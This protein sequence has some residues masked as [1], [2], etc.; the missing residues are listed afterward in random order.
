MAL[1]PQA[2]IKGIVSRALPSLNPDG[3]N[4]DVAVR[5][6]SYGEVFTMPAIRKSHV[7]ADEGSYYVANNA[8]TGLASAYNTSYTATAP[9]FTVYNNN[10]NLRVYLDYIGLVAI[11]AGASATTAGYTAIGVVVD[12]GNRYSSGG[13]SLSPVSPNMATSAASNVIIYSGAVTATAASANARTVVGIRNIRPALSASVINVIGDTWLLN[14]GGVEQSASGQISI[15]SGVANVI[16]QGLPPVI[17]G[18]N[19][20]ALVYLWYP[21]MSTPSAA[22]FAPEIGFWVR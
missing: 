19:Q 15:T 1:S 2:L 17:I 7:L 21:V 10:T 13:T 16:P 5:Q 3:F 14:F 12:Q 22:T 9:M 6:G 18:P 20:T 11:A 4:N 8:Q